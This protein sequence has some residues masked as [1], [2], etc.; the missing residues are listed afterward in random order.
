MGIAEV[1]IQV[2]GERRALVIGEFLAPIPCEGA[3]QLPRQ[4]LYLS[5]KRGHDTGGVLILDPGQHH[6]EGVTLD[7]REDV[8]VIGA[9]VQIA[10]PVD[11]DGAVIHGCGSLSD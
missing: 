1:D 11:R 10:F 7:E 3:A 8:G 4:V 6:V 5:G 2:Q 9:S